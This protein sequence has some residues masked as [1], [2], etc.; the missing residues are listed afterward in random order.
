MERATERDGPL[1]LVFRGV[2][3]SIGSPGK[4]TLRYG[5]HTACLT[6]RLAPESWLVLDGGS[7]LRTLHADL[8]PSPAGTLH[9]HVLFTHYHRDHIE[10]LMLFD[11]LYES[12]CRFTF[13]GHRWGDVGVREAL[14]GILRPPWASVALEETRSEKVYRDLDGAGIEIGGIR[15]STAPLRHPQGATAYRLDRGPRSIV[16][17]TDTEGGDPDH[18]DALRSLARDVDVLV[19]DAQYTPDEYGERRGRGHGTWEHA[20]RIARECGARRLVLFHHDPDRTD[21]ELDA[22]VEAARSAHPRVEAAH[23]GMSLAL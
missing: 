16:V 7:G 13:Y 22:I 4:S 19:V 2:R 12:A 5:G 11:P 6:A 17:A 1:R 18:D 14:I 21:D 3:G 8:P 10:G 20:T 9:F 23:E 15:I